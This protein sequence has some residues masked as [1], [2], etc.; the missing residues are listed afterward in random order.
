MTDAQSNEY[1]LTEYKQLNS[2]LA[3]DMQYC[4][5]RESFLPCS[6]GLRSSGRGM[7]REF[8]PRTPFCGAA[9]H[10]GDLRKNAPLSKR[11]AV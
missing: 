6:G 5:D 2:E 9:L 11:G 1:G 8:R 7:G 3:P 4:E 10:G